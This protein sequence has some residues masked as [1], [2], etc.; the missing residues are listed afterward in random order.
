MK[1]AAARLGMDRSPL[2]F[3]F[4]VSQDAAYLLVLMALLDDAELVFL[5]GP[6]QVDHELRKQRFL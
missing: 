4:D 3:G 5:Q 6:G 1:K 2:R